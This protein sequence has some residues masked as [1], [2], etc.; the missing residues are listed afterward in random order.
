METI[1][2]VKFYITLYKIYNDFRVSSCPYTRLGTAIL[3]ALRLNN[4]ANT[5]DTIDSKT[6]VRN[7]RL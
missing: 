4:T 7:M 3:T 1:D 5:I 6:P 2:V